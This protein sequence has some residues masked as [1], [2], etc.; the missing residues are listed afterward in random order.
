[1]K[2]LANVG[3]TQDTVANLDDGI[4]TGWICVTLGRIK[5]HELDTYVP[6]AQVEDFVGFRETSTGVNVVVQMFT[7]EKRAEIGIETLWGGILGS[8]EKKDRKIDEILGIGEVEEESMDNVDREVMGGEEVGEKMASG[9]ELVSEAAT[10]PLPQEF[11]TPA[12]AP[13]LHRLPSDPFPPASWEQPASSTERRG[14]TR[15]WNRR[16]SGG[17]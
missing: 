10:T 3:A 14:R 9:K 1:M 2:M 5:A 15:R 7:E 6:G 8:K 16:A 13:I 11:Q 17:E 12:P 4:R